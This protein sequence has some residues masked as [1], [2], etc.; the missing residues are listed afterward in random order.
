MKKTL[1]LI[2]MVL[3]PII[4]F[5]QW[6][7]NQSF[8]TLYTNQ[9]LIAFD[10]VHTSG[11]RVFAVGKK[12][13]YSSRMYYS[14]DFGGSWNE[15]TTDDNTTWQYYFANTKNNII[16]TYGIDLF[17]TVKFRKSID[18]GSSWNGQTINNSNFPYGFSSYNFAAINDTLILTSTSRS[19]GIIKSVDGGATWNSFTTFSDND[20]NK[21]LEDVI[22]YKDYFYLISGTNGK[23][24]FRSHRD[25]TSWSLFYETSGFSNSTEGLEITPE[26][27]IIIVKP[28][29]IVYSDDEGESWVTKTRQELGIS[30]SGTIV[31]TSLMGNSLMLTIQDSGPEPSRIILVDEAIETSTNITEGLTDYGSGTVLNSIRSTT[32]YTFATRSNDTKKLWVYKKSGGGVSNENLESPQQFALA[33]NY[34]N[35]FNPTTNIQFTLQQ[36]SLVSL[37]VYNMLGQEVATLI[38]GRVSTGVKTIEFDA[39]GL[40]SG[41]Y[42]YKLK[43]DNKVQ[44]R[45]MLLIK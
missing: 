26:G 6:S 2:L 33:Q 42:L 39:S 4:S 41:V 10:G 34:P 40:S 31:L 36:T 29:E 15:V 17:G 7:E 25:S 9:G 23:G 20:K 22:A 13:D 19:S 21:S 18:N 14:D 16:Y 12:A 37:K 24:V 28:T 45:K 1:L 27:R 3:D 35:P 38:N 5:A 32:N 11:E 30:N 43:A 44:T 8:D